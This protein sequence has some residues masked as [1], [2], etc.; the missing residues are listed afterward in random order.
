MVSTTISDSDKNNKG[1]RGVQQGR[2]STF[3]LIKKK[4]CRMKTNREFLPIILRK[5]MN[6]ERTR[7]RIITARTYSMNRPEPP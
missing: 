1:Q 6:A 4:Y 7:L 5:S 3:R 2:N